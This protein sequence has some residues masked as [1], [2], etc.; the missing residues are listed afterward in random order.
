M[1]RCILRLLEILILGQVPIGG[2]AEIDERIILKWILKT[3]D[4]TMRTVYV[5]LRMRAFINTVINLLL[6]R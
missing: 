2:P 5:W 1:Q 6:T 4:M 3:Q